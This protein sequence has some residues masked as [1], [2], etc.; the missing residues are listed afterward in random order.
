M[1]GSSLL[2]LPSLHPRPRVPGGP[3]CV[4]GLC[5]HLHK[6]LFRATL[7]GHQRWRMG[8]GAGSWQAPQILTQG[9]LNGEF[10]GPTYLEYGLE[11][12]VQVGMNPLSQRF[13]TQ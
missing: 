12:G 9:H 4:P 13:L 6:Q 3:L 2:P 8:L 1:M 11:R 10:Q 5:S 7:S